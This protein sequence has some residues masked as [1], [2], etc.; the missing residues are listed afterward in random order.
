MLSIPCLINWKTYITKPVNP[1]YK[2]NKKI[3]LTSCQSTMFD[4]RVITSTVTS[5]QA[6]WF[7]RITQSISGFHTISTRF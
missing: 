6:F 2:K 1:H 4:L 5:C 3:T 7:G